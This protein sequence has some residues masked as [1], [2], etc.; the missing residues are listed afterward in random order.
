[1]TDCVDSAFFEGPPLARGGDTDRRV[2]RCQE[3]LFLFRSQ[4]SSESRFRRSS[5][6]ASFTPPG[7]E[8]KNFFTF[9]RFRVRQ[10]RPERREASSL[11]F[12]PSGV[13]RSGEARSSTHPEAVKHDPSIFVSVVGAARRAPQ[14]A[15]RSPAV[16]DALVAP[17]GGPRYP[18]GCGVLGLVLSVQWQ[19]GDR[20]PYVDAQGRHG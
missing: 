9:V 7:A 18:V 13:G 2:R 4:A 11:V 1:M 20:G 17:Q 3:R 14:E 5:K 10:C 15:L 12:I 16:G 8:V 19:H 6:G